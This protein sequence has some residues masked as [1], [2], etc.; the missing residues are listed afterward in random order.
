MLKNNDYW[1][2][3]MELLEESQLKK[4]QAYVQDLEKQYRVASQ[5]IEKEISTW[6]S[7]FAINN[8]ITMAEAKKLLNTKELK[9]FKWN[10]KDY[11][12]FGEENALNQQ[13]MKELE[14]ASARVHVSRL[15]ALKL[16]MQQQVEV[17]YGNQTDG[18]DKLLRNVYSEGYY[19]T[20]W[21]IQKGFNI[22][23]DLHDLN[24]NQLDKLLSKPWTLDNKTFSDRLWGN[25][26]QLVG[27]LQTQLSQSVIRGQSPDK[28]IKVISEQFNVDKKKAGRL[29]MTES[30]AFASASQK[31]CFNALDVERFEIVAT[32]DNNTSAICQ[33]LD[34]HVFDM[35]DYQVGVTA[36]PFHPWCRTTT[37]PYFEDNYGERAARGADG[38]TYY[39]PGNM[40]YADWK[41]SFV[42]G[43]SK[44]GLKEVLPGQTVMAA[45]TFKEKIQDVK[46]TIA[47][48]GGKIE[49]S[50]IQTAG[51]AVQEELQV[52]R[53]DLK[54]EVDALEK[55]YKETGIEEVESQLSKLKQ[56]RRGLVDL[57]EVGLSDMN[58]L[59]EKYDELMKKKFQLNPI[60]SELQDKLRE[61]KG[62]YAGKL[63]DNAAE[64]KEKIAEIRNM[65]N[66]S[67]NVDAHLNN[68]RSPMRKVVKEAYDYYPNEWVDKSIAKSTLSPKK[69]DRGFYSDARKEI[70]IS[71]WNENGYLETAIHEL[72]HRFERAVPGIRDAEKL[73]YERRTAGDT[74]KWLGGRYD[75]SEKSRFDKFLNPYMG[76]D[77]GGS[78]YELVSMG[79]EYAYTNPT[80]LWE[81]EDFATW[82]Y[83]IL[84]LY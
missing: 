68:S 76:K 2:K 47:A 35:K 71:G 32:L 67:F 73:F 57:N 46:D 51:K 74:L 21:E 25:K 26:Q 84:S 43:G 56:A 8:N 17:L 77:Y 6:Y 36:P 1:K 24:S 45:K 44:E 63:K 70:A 7:R 80:K 79:F 31:D 42:D 10:V 9:E 55:Q 5:N 81:D 29:V 52:K 50:D 66:G 34:G 72:G 27:S 60:T 30:A 11:I 61:A 62:K 4:G 83:G 53:V 39:V 19:H 69:V 37:V 65:G 58:S 40:K 64:L 59:N 75:Y 14:N 18:L 54:A 33:D 16:Q 13:W 41:K 12:K 38:K 48:K 22:G 23:W 3:R 78:A 49:E 28:A 82:I 20:A 15:E